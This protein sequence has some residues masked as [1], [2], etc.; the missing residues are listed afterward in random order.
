MGVIC[1]NFIIIVY[2]YDYFIMFMNWGLNFYK[3]KK[4]LKGECSLNCNVYLRFLKLAL[5]VEVVE[6]SP[7]LVKGSKLEL[8]PFLLKGS[9]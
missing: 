6:L 4:S 8:S 9:K 5:G 2:C 1:L 3:G 7:K